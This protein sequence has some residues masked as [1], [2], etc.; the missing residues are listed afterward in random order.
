MHAIWE[1]IL[2]D[3]IMEAYEHSIIFKCP[4]GISR[5]FYPRFF[6]YSA[7]YP[8]KYVL[9]LCLVDIKLNSPGFF[10]P[11]FGTLANALVHVV[12]SRRR[13]LGV[14]EPT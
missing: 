6:T 8:K 5:Q 3:T 2:D 13:Q 12:R 10:L 11:Q 9:M 7:D 1:L 14:L 4:D